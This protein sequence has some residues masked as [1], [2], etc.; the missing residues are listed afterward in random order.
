MGLEA[1]RRVPIISIADVTQE[2]RGS[3]V[4]ARTS[5]RREQQELG[6]LEEQRESQL[7]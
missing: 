5:G 7:G 2:R 1:E 3:E 6:F 4:G